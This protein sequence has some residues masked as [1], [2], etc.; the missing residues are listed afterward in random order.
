MARGEWNDLQYVPV[1]VTRER[2]ISLSSTT[3]FTWNIKKRMVVRINVLHI[4][5][6]L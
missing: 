4:I 2:G 3:V 1:I 6:K 5:I